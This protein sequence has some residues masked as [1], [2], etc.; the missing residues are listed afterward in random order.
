[1]IS[2]IMIV[3]MREYSIRALPERSRHRRRKIFTSAPSRSR[4]EATPLPAF[5][6]NR[7]DLQRYNVIL[8]T[9]PQWFAANQFDH[10]RVRPVQ[11]GKKLVS[12]MHAGF[13]SWCQERGL[14]AP[15]LVK[16]G[17]MAAQL[18]QKDKIGGRVVYLNVE[19]MPAALS[20]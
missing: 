1:M 7:C 2:T 18:Y 8:A 13:C 10:D 5:M 9:E 17:K 12:D 15:S 14:E 4:T 6:P 19:L 20:A 16:F 11:G 3:M